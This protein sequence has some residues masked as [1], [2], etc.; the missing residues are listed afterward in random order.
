[1]LAEALSHDEGRVIIDLGAVH[2]LSLSS[3]GIIVRAQA[4]LR[5]RSRSLTVRSPNANVL[6]IIRICGLEDIVGTAVGAQPDKTST[7]R[8][9][10]VDVQPS[11]PVDLSGLPG[12]LDLRGLIEPGGCNVV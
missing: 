11:Q 5:C 4:E 1:M 10:L 3:L 6:R 2:F 12:G 7:R 8:L 9:H